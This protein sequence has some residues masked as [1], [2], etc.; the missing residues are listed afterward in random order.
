MSSLNEEGAM[1]IQFL[2]MQGYRRCDIAACN[3]PYWHGGNASKRLTEIHELL[4]NA[5]CKPYEKTAYKAI[6]ALI[7]ERDSLRTPQPTAKENG[8]VSGN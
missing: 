7:A 2:E 6:E 3:C 8:D 4:S 5:G 1:A